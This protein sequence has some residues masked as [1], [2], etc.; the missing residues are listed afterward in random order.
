MMHAPTGVVADGVVTATH[1]AAEARRI[2]R[3]RRSSSSTR[4][5]SKP[6]AVSRACECAGAV[7]TRCRS[8]PAGG[9]PFGVEG[10]PPAR[11]RRSADR[12]ASSASAAATSRRSA[13]GS[14]AGR[15]FTDDDTADAEAGGRRQRDVRAPRVPRRRR[16]RP[17]HRLDGAADRAAR[18]QPDVPRRPDVPARGPFRIVGVV[19]DVHQAPLGQARRA[20]H[21]SHDRASSR[22]AR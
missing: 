8:I 9:C 3:G 18:P 16:A 17:A 12:A 7:P 15:F 20:G 6:S 5:C 1:A 14:L 13:H 10:R 2:R 4:R 11:R 22:S 19:A 21:L